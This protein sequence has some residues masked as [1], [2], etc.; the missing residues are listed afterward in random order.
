MFNVESQGTCILVSVCGMGGPLRFS[1]L[2]R[3]PV[4]V[5]PI[6]AIPFRRTIVLTSRFLEPRRPDRTHEQKALLG[7]YR[8]LISA[9]VGRRCRIAVRAI[10]AR[11]I[12]CQQTPLLLPGALTTGPQIPTPPQQRLR[13]RAVGH[14]PQRC[15]KFRGVRGGTVRGRRH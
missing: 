3:F 2:C 14:I 11:A 12:C 7:S 13:C 5:K 1:A 15:P 8:E 6:Q 9:G 10:A 4:P